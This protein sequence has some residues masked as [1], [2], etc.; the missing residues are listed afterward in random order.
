MNSPFLIGPSV[1]LRPLE[2]ADARTIVP[3]LND[4]EVT[5][6]LRRYQPMTLAEEEEF[7]RRLPESATD[8]ALGIALRADDRLVGA[9][10]LHKM[11]TRNRHAELG[12]FIGDKSAWGKGHGTE[13]TRLLVRHAFDTLNLNRVWLHVYEYNEA[14]LRVYQKVGFRTEGRL[15]QDTFRD[16][17]FWDTIVMGVLREEWEAVDYAPT[18]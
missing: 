1:Y 16:G 2:I 4:P 17:R 15:R 3:W 5:R 9:T 12:I 6:N 18:P 8:L 14:A 10:G 7:L 13:A 11:D